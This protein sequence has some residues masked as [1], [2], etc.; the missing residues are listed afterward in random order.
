MKGEKKAWNG[1]KNAIPCVVTT[2]PVQ[3]GSFL[4]LLSSSCL[5]DTTQMYKQLAAFSTIRAKIVVSY[6]CLSFPNCSKTITAEVNV[7]QENK[8]FKGMLGPQTPFNQRGKYCQ[9][10]GALSSSESSK[11]AILHFLFQIPRLTFLS[12]Q[13]HYPLTFLSQFLFGKKDSKPQQGRRLSAALRIPSQR[14]YIS[15]KSL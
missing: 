9:F 11:I 3:L 6:R 7:P 1:A 12:E 15:H 14:T 10:E 4:F 5:N 8:C 13:D 2:S